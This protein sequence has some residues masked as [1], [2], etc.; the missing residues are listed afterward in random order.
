MVK[1]PSLQL[2]QPWLQTERETGRETFSF[3]KASFA[4]V[5]NSSLIMMKTILMQLMKMTVM[6]MKIEVVM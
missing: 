5:N 2:C 3:L 6:L 4:I 1:P